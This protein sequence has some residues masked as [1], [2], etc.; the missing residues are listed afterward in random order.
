MGRTMEI[1]KRGRENLVGG[2]LGVVGK[3]GPGRQG[4]ER[5]KER[6]EGSMEAGGVWGGGVSLSPVWATLSQTLYGRLRARCKVQ[7]RPLS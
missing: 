6:L 1:G 2:R 3:Q 4:E 7:P 5:G